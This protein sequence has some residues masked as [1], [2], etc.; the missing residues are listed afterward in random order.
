MLRLPFGDLIF[1]FTESLASTSPPPLLVGHLLHF[2]RDGVFR[3]Q[4]FGAYL[5]HIHR[6]RRREFR[7][8]LAYHASPATPAGLS[9][10]QINHSIDEDGAAPEL[11][12]RFGTVDWRIPVC[13]CVW[14]VPRRVGHLFLLVRLLARSGRD[15]CDVRWRQISSVRAHQL[16]P[17][18]EAM[19]HITHHHYRRRHHQPPIPG[20]RAA[21]L[22]PRPMYNP[23][24]P[25]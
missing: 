12:P 8:I 23:R 10:N 13:P 24:P 4:G 14:V 2:V 9:T 5:F 15:R 6:I 21:Y 18:G 7:I 3:G 1:S 25:F 22:P 20:P 17:D 16:F 11:S 19:F